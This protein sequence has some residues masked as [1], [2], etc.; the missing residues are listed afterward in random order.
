MSKYVMLYIAFIIKNVNFVT[1][2]C[3]GL[4]AVFIYG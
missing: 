1:R 4:E 2:T 3:K